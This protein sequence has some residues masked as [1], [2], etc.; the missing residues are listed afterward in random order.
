MD[1]GLTQ[2]EFATKINI[3]YR[4]FQNIESGKVDIKL[5]TIPKI[6]KVIPKSKKKL[7]RIPRK[8]FPFIGPLQKPLI[9]TATMK[10]VMF[11]V[12]E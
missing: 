11:T 8:L 3:N 12:L 2:K 4:H 1:L 6:L 9:P 7:K 10:N 5:S